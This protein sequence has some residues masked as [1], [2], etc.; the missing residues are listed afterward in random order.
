MRRSFIRT[1]AI[2]LLSALAVIACSSTPTQRSA[3][4]T[5]D[6]SV[7][8]GKVKAALV[9]NDVVKAGDVNVDTYKGVVE[10]NG[11][12]DTQAEKDAATKAAKSVTGVKEVRNNV[13]LKSTK[14]A[15]DR[16]AGQVVDDATITTKVKTKLIEDETTKAHQI[17]VDTRSGVVQLGGFVDSAAA[18]DRAGELARSVSGVKDVQNELQVKS[19]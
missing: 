14:M 11:W 15:A 6:D 19:Q 7:L 5:V 17:D 12:V 18:K 8:T 4:E 13:Q 16:S 3:G 2:A 9:D 10:L 1:S